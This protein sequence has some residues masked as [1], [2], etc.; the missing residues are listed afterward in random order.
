M[1]ASGPPGVWLIDDS[2]L[3]RYTISIAGS[4][5]SGRPANKI[6]LQVIASA[7]ADAFPVDGLEVPE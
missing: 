6:A 1:M 7:I 4:D 5:V 2:D 3:A